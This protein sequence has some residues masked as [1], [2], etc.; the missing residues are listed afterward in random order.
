[1]ESGD[2]LGEGPVW[3]EGRLYWVDIYGRRLHA[4]EP[5]SGAYRSWAM[6]DRIG[7]FIPTT[8]G[9]FIAGFKRGLVRIDLEGLLIADLGTPEPELPDNRFND[10]KCDLEGRLWAGTLCDNNR[11]PTGRLYRYTSDEGFRPMDGPYLVTNGPA[12]SPDGSVLYHTDSE[13]GII[14]AFDLSDSG[15]LA[16]KRVFVRMRREDGLPDGMTTDTD[17]NLWVARFGGAGIDR[18]RRDGALLERIALPVSNVTS[19]TFGGEHLDRLFVT[20]ARL[21]L[22]DEAL[23]AQPLAGGL[24]EVKDPGARGLA[25]RPYRG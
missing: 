11:T 8:S 16:N 2:I 4:F 23:A 10:A 25:V 24:F 19:C 20:T 21:G 3:H 12:I 18:Y 13:A 1:V 15:E 5:D 22:S 17:G 14:H 6:P 9:D 7:F